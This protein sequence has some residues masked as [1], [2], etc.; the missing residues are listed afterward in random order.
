[1]KTS[2]I[3]GTQQKGR[4]GKTIKKEEAKRESVGKGGLGQQPLASLQ[5]RMALCFEGRKFSE[6]SK[7][8]IEWFHVTGSNFDV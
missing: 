4:L 2:E 5:F 7:F 6:G 1:M 3:F 8:L